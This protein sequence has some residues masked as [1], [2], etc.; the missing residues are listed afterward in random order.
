MSAIQK[1]RE[2]LGINQNQL[3]VYLGISRSF[4]N[5]VEKVKKTLSVQ[6]IDKLLALQQLAAQNNQ[7]LVA[8]D[9]AEQ[10]SGLQ[11]F[12]QQQTQKNL[13]QK[14]KWQNKLQ[15]IQVNY[16]KALQLLQTTRALQNSLPIAAKKDKLWCSYIEAMAMQ[17]LQKNSLIVQQKLLQK[18]N[19]L[20]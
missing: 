18:I 11:T 15:L 14:I 4:L 8:A 2:G 12:L 3:A 17:Q 6:H 5:E 9:I 20:L 1:I 10:E 7:H 13:P 16:T 19:S